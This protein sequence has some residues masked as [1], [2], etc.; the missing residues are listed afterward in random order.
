[1]TRSTNEQGFISTVYEGKTHEDLQNLSICLFSIT[2][3]PRRNKKDER[4]IVIRN[5]ARLW[6]RVHSEEGSAFL[7][8][9]IEEEVY[10]CQPPGFEDPEFLDKVYK[11]LQVTQKDDEI[12][13]SQDKYVD[14]ILKKFG[15]LTV[16]IAS[17]PMETSK[18]IL[19]DAKAEDVDVHLYRSMIGSLMYLTTF[20]PDIMFAD[21]PFDLEAYTDSDYAGASLE[22]EI[23]KEVVNFLEEIDSNGN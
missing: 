14:E 21:S 13:I 15:F 4:G 9:K 19:K 6:Y 10:V 18:P 11:D 8:G 22:C 7:Y 1:M 17:T 20:R 16:R 3:R 23:P 5:K 2:S 12:F